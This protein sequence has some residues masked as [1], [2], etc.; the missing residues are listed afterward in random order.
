MTEDVRDNTAAHRFELVVDRHLSFSDYTLDGNVI[1]FT[2]TIVPPALEGHGVAS[3]LISGALAQVRARGL[4]VRPVCKFVKAYIERHP[5]W[6]D[7]LA[8]PLA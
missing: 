7:L 6:Q 1:T 5:E 3:R 2:H 4:K 8:E